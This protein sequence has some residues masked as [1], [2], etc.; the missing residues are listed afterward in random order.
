ML[1]D[2][3]FEYRVGWFTADTAALTSFKLKLCGPELK[4]L[5]IVAL[6]LKWIIFNSGEY[7]HTRDGSDSHHR[8][9]PHH[10]QRAAFA[11]AQT[12]SC[13]STNILYTTWKNYSSQL[14]AITA[15]LKL[16]YLPGGHLDIDA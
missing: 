4:L 6:H 1:R 14:L 16:P 9:R 2:E 8:L 7:L 5:I 11:R 3:T 15:C 12:N 10:H 13:P